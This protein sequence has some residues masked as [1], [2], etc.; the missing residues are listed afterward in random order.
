MLKNKQKNNAQFY[1][2]VVYNGET[3]QALYVVSILL[4][5]Q[6]GITVKQYPYCNLLFP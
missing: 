6:T 5:V 4:E 3:S 2:P 1:S